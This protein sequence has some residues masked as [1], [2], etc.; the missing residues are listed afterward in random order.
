M[1]RHDLLKRA[2]FKRHF[3]R[4]DKLCV[5]FLNRLCALVKRRRVEHIVMVK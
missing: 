4:I 5:P 2:A 1:V 3:I